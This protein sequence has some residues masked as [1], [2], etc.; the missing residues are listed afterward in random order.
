LSGTFCVS[1]EPAEVSGWP[2]QPTNLLDPLGAKP[3]ALFRGTTRG[4]LGGSGTQRAGVTPTSTD[5]GVATAFATNAR[6]FGGA[7]V[8][9]A[10][11]GD[12]AG[13]ATYEGLIAS[14]LEVGVDL[15]PSEFAQRVG[16]TIS[17]ADARGLL[18]GLGIYIP[19]SIPLGD[20]S[21]TLETTP[22]L[23]P[24]QIQQFVEGA[25]KLG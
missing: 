24:A 17:A 9:I 14:E 25:L 4:Y 16:T 10:L 12:L 20:L 7:I 8:Q 15:A 21:P 13:V 19:A 23:S 6:Q 1:T 18:R 2:N 22:K 3:Q 11:P 5:P